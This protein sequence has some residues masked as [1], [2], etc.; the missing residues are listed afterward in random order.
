M[1]SSEGDVLTSTRRARSRCERCAEMSRAVDD[2]RENETQPIWTGRERGRRRR[3][4]EYEDE[5]ETR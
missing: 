3:G 2:E 5:N 1:Y 4:K